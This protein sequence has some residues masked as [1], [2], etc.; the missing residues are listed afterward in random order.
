MNFSDNIH[1]DI[2]MIALVIV[3]VTL[4]AA[5]WMVL[6]ALRVITRL[7]LPGL[8]EEEKAAR[9]LA[10]QERRTRYKAN[11]N[12]LWGLR[13]ISEEKDLLIEHEYDGI[14][15][16]DNPTPAWFMGLFYASVA[17]AVVY[18]CVYHVFG[19][20]MDQHQEYTVEMQQA[21]AARQVYLA[22]AAN[23]VDENTV[24][25]DL[26]PEVIAAGAATYAQYCAVCHG[27]AGEGLIGPNLTDEYWLHGGD[28]KSL[29]HTIKYGVPD[30]GMVPWEQN[31]TP[32]QIAEV[33]N[34]IISLRGT[35]PPNPK[36]PEGTKE[37]PAPVV[38]T[39]AAR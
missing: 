2:L 27:A 15:E 28:V 18:L 8:E 32:A 39:T 20:G 36:A 4:L 12:K 35:N 21:E 3:M 7:T 31:L 33:S 23:L 24:E 19:W 37:A 16:L 22:Q 1:N 14:R 29:F 6:K 38:Q 5:A 13:P 30:K 9:I 11:W 25:E 26:A 10:K 17:F 34:Y